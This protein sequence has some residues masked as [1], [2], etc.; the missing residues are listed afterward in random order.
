MNNTLLRPNR[1]SVE[2]FTYTDKTFYADAS[3]LEQG[4]DRLMFDRVW[5]DSCDEGFTLVNP[6]TGGEAVFYLNDTQKDEEGD[7]TDW[8]LIPVDKE[9]VAQG[10][11]AVVWND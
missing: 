8:R 11:T 10:I 4:G 9:L 7:I 3:D 5:A 2:F 1:L 6:A